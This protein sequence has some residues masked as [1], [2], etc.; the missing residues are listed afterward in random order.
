MTSELILL[1][2]FHQVIL[3]KGKKGFAFV[4]TVINEEWKYNIYMYIYTHTHIYKH[5]YII[6]LYYKVYIMYKIEYIMIYMYTHFWFFQTTERISRILWEA[7]MCAI[8]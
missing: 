4:I 6:L 3:F 5:T 2:L 7:K 1:Q 8:I